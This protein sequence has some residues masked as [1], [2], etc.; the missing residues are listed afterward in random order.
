M[1]S[2]KSELAKK[3]IA[4]FLYDY[5]SNKNNKAKLLSDWNDIDNVRVV[6]NYGFGRGNQ[7][8]A[9]AMVFIVD[10]IHGTFSGDDIKDRLWMAIRSRQEIIHN[11]SDQRFLNEIDYV[12]RLVLK[13]FSGA[14]KNNEK[15]SFLSKREVR[16]GLSAL[17]SI[18][19][20]IDYDI[21][22][23]KAKLISDKRP[24][25]SSE[26]G[27]HN[28]LT[29]MDIDAEKKSLTD[30]LTDLIYSDKQLEELFAFRKE[31]HR[32]SGNPVIAGLDSDVNFYK[33]KE[34]IRFLAD[35]AD[36]YVEILDIWRVYNPKLITD[37]TTTSKLIQELEG[38][39]M[40]MA[41]FY[42]NNNRP[43]QARQL[44]ELY[45][46]IRQERAHIEAASLLINK[47]GADR[48]NALSLEYNLLTSINLNSP[49][50]RKINPYGKDL[51]FSYIRHT[52]KKIFNKQLDVIST[53]SW[54]SPSRSIKRF[55]LTNRRLGIVATFNLQQI[56]DV[57]GAAYK[58]SGAKLPLS[59]AVVALK[60]D[61]IPS[62]KRDIEVVE[63]KIK[64]NLPLETLESET[65]I[66]KQLELEEGNGP[67]NRS[68]AY[69]PQDI[70]PGDD[71]DNISTALLTDL[72]IDNNPRTAFD[73]IQLSVAE[74]GEIN[75]TYMTD[76]FTPEEEKRIKELTR[77]L[78]HVFGPDA[79]K[80]AE[81]FVL[82]SR[83]MSNGPGGGGGDYGGGGGGDW[84][85][86][87]WRKMLRADADAIGQPEYVDLVLNSDTLKADYVEY[88]TYTYRIQEELE[89]LERTSDINKSI[90]EIVENSKNTANAEIDSIVENIRNIFE[91]MGFDV[92][93]D[94]FDR[95]SLLKSTTFGDR[96]STLQVYFKEMSANYLGKLY[97]Q[98]DEQARDGFRLFSNDD[99]FPIFTR[100]DG[101]IDDLNPVNLVS[102]L[103][104]DFETEKLN[105]RNS[106]WKKQGISFGFTADGYLIIKTKGIS[107]WITVD[108]ISLEGARIL[109]GLMGF[110]T[111]AHFSVIL[112]NVDIWVLL[113]RNYIADVVNGFERRLN[114]GNLTPH[115]RAIFSRE[116]QEWQRALDR[117]DRSYER[118]LK[119]QYRENKAALEFILYSQHPSLDRRSPNSIGN[120]DLVEE[121]RPM[122]ESRDFFE[123]GWD[124]DN[125]MRQRPPTPPNQP[126]QPT[127]N[128]SDS[129]TDHIDLP[130]D[131]DDRIAFGDNDSPTK[132]SIQRNL[133]RSRRRELVGAGIVRKEQMVTTANS[134]QEALGQHVTSER[135]DVMYDGMGHGG[136]A[137]GYQDTPIDSIPR[138]VHDGKPINS[139]PPSDSVEGSVSEKARNGSS[140]SIETRKGDFFNVPPVDFSKISDADDWWNAWHSLMLLD[141]ALQF[142]MISA[143]GMPDFVPMGGGRIS[144]ILT[145]SHI[146][147]LMNNMTF[148][149]INDTRNSFNR[150]RSSYSV[151]LSIGERVGIIDPEVANQ[152]RLAFAGGNFL[153]GGMSHSLGNLQSAYSSIDMVAMFS[154]KMEQSEIDTFKNMLP[155]DFWPGARTWEEALKGY[156]VHN[157]IELREKDLKFFR[158]AEASAVTFEEFKQS[159]RAFWA[160]EPHI[161]GELVKRHSEFFAKMFYGLDKT[162]S[163]KEWAATMGLSEWLQKVVAST[164][165]QPPK[166]KKVDPLETGSKKHRPES[167]ESITKRTLAFGSNKP[168]YEESYSR[169]FFIRENAKTFTDRVE[170]GYGVIVRVPA[171]Q[172][173]KVAELSGSEDWKL[174][175]IRKVVEKGD[176]IDDYPKVIVTEFAGEV[177]GFVEDGSTRIR[178]AAERG[179]EIEVAV[180]MGPKDDVFQ[181]AISLL[182]GIY[183][184]QGVNI[185]LV[186]SRV[187]IH[188]AISG[189]PSNPRGIEGFLPQADKIVIDEFGGK[190]FKAYN[191]KEATLNY[192]EHVGTLYVKDKLAQKRVVSMDELK[193]SL[194]RAVSSIELPDKVKSWKTL[195]EMLG[196][197]QEHFVS[198]L[199]DEEK[200]KTFFYKLV[201]ELKITSITEFDEKVKAVPIF[202]FLESLKDN[203]KQILRISEIDMSGRW[204]RIRR[205]N[206]NVPRITPGATLKLGGKTLLGGLPFVGGIYLMF[207]DWTTPGAEAIRPFTVTKR[208]L[209]MNTTDQ[210]RYLEAHHKYEAAYTPRHGMLNPLNMEDIFRYAN[211]DVDAVLAELKGLEQSY[212]NQLDYLINR[213]AQNIT[214]IVRQRRFNALSESMLERILEIGAVQ[215]HGK[216]IRLTDLI[217]ER[218]N[219][220]RRQGRF[221]IV[222]VL[223]LLEEY[224]DTF[225][226]P[227]SVTSY[228]SDGETLQRELLGTSRLLGGYEKDENNITA[229]SYEIGLLTSQWLREAIVGATSLNI[230]GDMIY[231]LDIFV[232]GANSKNVVSFRSDGKEYSAPK[233]EAR[234]RVGMAHIKRITD[235]DF[236][237]D[238]GLDLDDKIFFAGANFMQSRLFGIG[239][240]HTPDVAAQKMS[241][242][243]RMLAGMHRQQEWLNRENSGNEILGFLNQAIRPTLEDIYTREGLPQVYDANHDLT[244][245]ARDAA[246]QHRINVA[247]WVGV[248]SIVGGVASTFT[249]GGHVGGVAL[250][251]E[252]INILWDAWEMFLDIK[253]QEWTRG[254]VHSFFGNRNTYQIPSLNEWNS[255]HDEVLRSL[256]TAI[257]FANPNSI[258]DEV[259]AIMDKIYPKLGQSA[260]G[261]LVG[262]ETQYRFTSVAAQRRLAYWLQPPVSK[263][264]NI[265]GGTAYY[266]HGE[267]VSKEKYNEE[268]KKWLDFILVPGRDDIFG[269]PLDASRYNSQNNNPRWDFVV[270]S[271]GQDLGG[272]HVDDIRR[273]E[274]INILLSL[275]MIE[276]SN[277]IRQRVEEE[278]TSRRSRQLVEN[279]GAYAS[280]ASSIV[281]VEDE[282]A[283]DIAIENI[284]QRMR[285]IKKSIQNANDIETKRKL[286][287]IYVL[288]RNEHKNIIEQRDK[289]QNSP[290]LGT[291][292]DVSDKLGNV[293][294]GKQVVNASV[295]LANSAVSAVD[296]IHDRVSQSRGQDERLAEAAK[297]GPEYRDLENEDVPVITWDTIMLGAE[298]LYPEIRKKKER[299]QKKQQQIDEYRAQIAYQ[300]FVDYKNLPNILSNR[301]ASEYQSPFISEISAGQ[302]PIN[303]SYDF[304]SYMEQ[305]H[306]QW[307]DHLNRQDILNSDKSKELLGQRIEEYKQDI[308]RANVLSLGNFYKK[309]YGSVFKNLSDI[310]LPDDKK[311]SLFL[312]YSEIRPKPIPGVDL[313]EEQKEQDAINKIALRAGR[314]VFGNTETSNDRPV[315]IRNEADIKD[316]ISKLLNWLKENEDSFDDIAK[317]KAKFD[318]NQESQTALNR[319]NPEE[320]EKNIKSNIIKLTGWT[321]TDEEGN[322]ETLSEDEITFKE[323]KENLE[324]VQSGDFTKL[325]TPVLVN[326]VDLELEEFAIGYAMAL[327]DERYYELMEGMKNSILAKYGLPGVGKKEIIGNDVT[328]GYYRLSVDRKEAKREGNWTNEQ[329]RQYQKLRKSYHEANNEYERQRG[330]IERE[331]YQVLR[332]YIIAYKKA[333]WELNRK[334]RKGRTTEEDKQN[335]IKIAKWLSGHVNQKKNLSPIAIANQ[336]MAAYKHNK[337]MLINLQA[338]QAYTFAITSLHAAL[339]NYWDSTNNAIAF[340]STKN[341]NAKEQQQA[342]IADIITE[343]TYKLTKYTAFNYISNNILERDIKSG[344]KADAVADDTPGNIGPEPAPVNNDENEAGQ[345]ATFADEV[346]LPPITPEPKGR[347]G[348]FKPEAFEM[349]V[350]KPGQR[351]DI[352]IEPGKPPILGSADRI[353]TVEERNARL[354]RVVVNGVDN[355]HINNPLSPINPDV[356]NV[357]P[358]VIIKPDVED[359]TN[360][361]INHYI[362][363]PPVQNPFST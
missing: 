12:I 325:I 227:S 190:K 69:A 203:V 264:D 248:I 138:D 198:G 7:Y 21:T 29:E 347:G 80:E 62:L 133:S 297:I 163:V 349:P 168:T 263:Q 202:G 101:D 73:K 161:D 230:L 166:T 352:I 55:S 286:T 116:R 167:P 266:V 261:Q 147:N 194:I 270:V 74:D 300:N 85:E 141:E 345:F 336:R 337:Q 223:M 350:R 199:I 330:Q 173:I 180:K 274:I 71:S 50:I 323:Y 224:A 293:F 291:L 235:I 77:H 43:R 123:G 155:N 113:R 157:G 314:W 229:Y 13:D 60:D 165:N 152:L 117:L 16:D 191:W 174:D 262:V 58:L 143:M 5:S 103:V 151:L 303:Y 158:K 3:A 204:I 150:V 281:D 111:P 137:H 296:M 84:D 59:A 309:I 135:L 49:E 221:P 312:G 243:Q 251:W 362:P 4:A 19:S 162:D 76:E 283:Y 253:G 324:K 35:L 339:Q 258:D 346:G 357:S 269:Q 279:A 99:N 15:I 154:F 186:R 140:L 271:L 335:N 20:K 91:N 87:R 81:A 247:T 201:Q 148:N 53:R 252:G 275:G 42:N 212:T 169:I 214:N 40:M 326:T 257:N 75:L 90:P 290:T 68:K 92:N 18:L 26:P 82:D 63:Y 211:F 294:V 121:T 208:L 322:I 222:D 334:Q 124:D 284:E 306:Q 177:H 160:N 127:Q 246:R 95:F 254:N 338:M 54:I 10:E 321:V 225:T 356:L 70:I 200:F 298:K 318:M 120:I 268:L 118:A 333:L 213:K 37:S 360:E 104:R 292:K 282:N 278:V 288:L 61:I 30:K 1:S 187:F 219:S 64:D 57:I 328:S 79:R 332:K 34:Y 245:R 234:F 342:D 276:D 102:S 39:V 67:D 107:D 287:K 207:L 353:E 97:R 105:N 132:N 100:R 119:S 239:R 126:D 302:E 184:D 45:L 311:E 233:D 272:N 86:P 307:I 17:K 32:R 363:K 206:A 139:L 220:L 109:A 83:N 320:L 329:E 14:N 98:R 170:N 277:T 6:A 175:S 136:G 310:P 145:T 218:K 142:R 66:Q 249:G 188:G 355:G 343:A 52:W 159:L 193:A 56:L 189:T 128:P 226:I 197:L 361:D 216:L 304:E 23:H 209:E 106:L 131:F 260:F 89:K 11:W 114:S 259:D 250:A 156:A 22:R 48:A 36:G 25:I 8:R 125:D 359:D 195:Y 317:I 231:A 181:N 153:W 358:P 289:K 33:L 31:Y 280:V 273:R 179:L 301:N 110:L 351:I 315:F 112:E 44:A 47:T 308:K 232:N 237:K 255:A 51:Q 319:D 354:G 196:I 285:D 93:A 146:Y 41:E 256:M 46:S 96:L 65:K 341:K 72:D 108:L 9:S 228:Y 28:E 122:M 182:K 305:S 244:E 340:M 313:T 331:R 78:E 27:M 183:G 134:I 205:A 88:E 192:I 215:V 217:E 2:K 299:R 295:A 185:R 344:T 265:F 238:V 115:D 316:D 24:Q 172:L 149:E 171:E 236:L 130:D 38:I 210:R 240:V 242:A 164:D 267:P 94:D 129:T 327:V 348:K 241:V 144:Q 176:A 178:V